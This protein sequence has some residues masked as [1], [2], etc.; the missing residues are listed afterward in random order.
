MLDQCD[1]TSRWHIRKANNAG[2]RGA[3]KVDKRTKIGVDRD[4]SAPLRYS[5]PA[6][7]GPATSSRASRTS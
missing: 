5:H 4:Q 3:G 1:A 2:M 6:S 7:P